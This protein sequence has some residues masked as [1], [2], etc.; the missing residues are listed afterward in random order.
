MRIGIGAELERRD[1]VV[2]VTMTA[3][4]P[5]DCTSR[6]SQPSRPKPLTKTSFASAIVLASAGVGA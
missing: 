2:A 5:A 3:L 1:A 4:P 6:G